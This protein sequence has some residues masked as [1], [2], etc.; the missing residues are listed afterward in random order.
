MSGADSLMTDPDEKVA[1]LKTAT[2]EAN[3]ALADLKACM[4]EL[5]ALKA[6]LDK[7]EV[8]TARKLE[9]HMDAAAQSEIS[10]LTEF[11]KDAIEKATDAVYKRFDQLRDILLG[12]GPE[13]DGA[14]IPELIDELPKCH[15]CFGKLTPGGHKC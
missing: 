11:T 1:A 9:I 4:K 15:K 7:T 5:R 12:E 6:E 14:S 3:E 13:R 8:I 2:R 10:Q